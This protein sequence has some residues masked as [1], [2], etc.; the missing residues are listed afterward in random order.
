LSTNGKKIDVGCGE[1]PHVGYNTYTDIYQPNTSIEG[2]F[3]LCSM[4]NMPFADKEFAYSRCHHVIEHVSNPD[5][6]CKELIRVSKKGTLWF[7]TPQ[8][9]LLFGRGDHRWFI[10]VENNKLLFVARRFRPYSIKISCEKSV[11]FPW[12]GGFE[13][14]VVY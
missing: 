10:F 1:R 6:A 3:V 5:C 12:E 4:E 7:P 2:N 13:W 14:E 8:A 11:E 9:E